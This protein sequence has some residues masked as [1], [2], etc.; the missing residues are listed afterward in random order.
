M[1][2]LAELIEGGVFENIEQAR[3][4]IFS[5]I[6]GYYNRVRLHSSL[7]YKSPLEFEMESKSKME[8]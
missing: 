8:K 2:E 1:K 6:E 5:Y 7:G 4:E 3:S